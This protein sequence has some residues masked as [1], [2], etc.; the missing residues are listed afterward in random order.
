M[1]R[2]TLG[3]GRV[4]NSDL[5]AQSGFRRRRD[6]PAILT[7]DFRKASS[8]C[9]GAALRLWVTGRGIGS[10]QR[11]R[12]GGRF[13]LLHSSTVS[14]P[15]LTGPVGRV[16]TGRLSK[17][18]SGGL[19]VWRFHHQRSLNCHTRWGLVTPTVVPSS[20]LPQRR[21]GMKCCATTR[22][23]KPC[24]IDADRIHDT[25]GYCHV[26]DPEGLFRDQQKARREERK[27][28][29]ESRRSPK[30]S[31]PIAPTPGMDAPLTIGP[32]AGRGR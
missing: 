9:G 18:G 4:L 32:D 10:I 1:G 21:F 3:L 8:D 25:Y 29:R 16:P 17:G 28:L 24:S 14:S 23:G 31:R 20:Q 26:H 13:S 12:R 7:I 2:G 6:A 30:P 11:S 15:L 19:R 22:E 5:F 27:V